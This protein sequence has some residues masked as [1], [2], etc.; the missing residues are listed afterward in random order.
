MAE[1]VEVTPGARTEAFPEI[2]PY[3][4]GWLRVSELHEIYYEESGNR[5]GNPVIFL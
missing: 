5:D 4:H 3:N 2:E 1:Q